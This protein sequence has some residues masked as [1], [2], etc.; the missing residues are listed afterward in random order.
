MLSGNHPSQQP[1]A[2]FSWNIFSCVVKAVPAY[3][4]SL[5]PTETEEVPKAFQIPKLGKMFCKILNK[6]LLNNSV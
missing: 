4:R 2:S 5:D 1:S 3:E 6:N